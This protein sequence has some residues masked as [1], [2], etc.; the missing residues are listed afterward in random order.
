MPA[1]RGPRTDGQKPKLKPGRPKGSQNKNTALI[2][3]MILAAL[4]GVGGEAYLQRQA[5]ENPGPFM[6][7]LGRIMP[8]QVT[9]PNDGPVQVQRVERVIVDPAKD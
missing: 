8:T 7:L 9:G 2:K 3:D 4:E 6:T 1:P 5:E